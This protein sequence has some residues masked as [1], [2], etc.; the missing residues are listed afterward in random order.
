MKRRALFG[1][2]AAI[3]AAVAVAP[4]VKAEAAPEPRF[5]MYDGED[6]TPLY[7]KS[8]DGT[9]YVHPSVQAIVDDATASGY[10]RGYDIATGRAESR[11]LWNAQPGDHVAV[12][13]HRLVLVPDGLSQAVVHSDGYRI[14][15]RVVFEPAKACAGCDIC[16]IP[17]FEQ[18]SQDCAAR[19]CE[20]SRVMTADGA[21]V[22]YTHGDFDR[23]Q[24]DGFDHG[25][26]ARVDAWRLSLHEKV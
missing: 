20:F 17:T 6:T 26:G 25:H 23:Y 22:R 7:A 21:V 10:Q 8:S 11:A 18:M 9:V 1:R 14:E 5:R 4:V 2:L 13:P 24:A 16:T 3:A 15:R 12:D 19:G